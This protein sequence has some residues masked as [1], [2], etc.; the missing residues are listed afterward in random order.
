MEVEILVSRDVK[1]FSLG[2]ELKYKG[3][4]IIYDDNKIT[5][6]FFYFPN[7]KRL[8]I[9]NGKTKKNSLKQVKEKINII[10]ILDNIY[11]NR[12]KNF[13]RDKDINVLY[14]LPTLFYRE[15]SLFIKK[16]NYKKNLNILYNKYSN[17]VKNGINYTYY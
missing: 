10:C 3:T 2:S 4:S 14:N 12:F 6:L 15:L 1:L 5:F 17:G 11:F 13:I 8:Y 9:V 16:K 7:L